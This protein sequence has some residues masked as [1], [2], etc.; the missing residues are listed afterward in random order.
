MNQESRSHN[1]FFMSEKNAREY[2]EHSKTGARRRFMNLLERF[3]KLDIKGKYLEVGCGP[4]VLACMVANQHPDVK[5]TATD[6]SPQMLSIAKENLEADKKDRIQFGIAD[7]CDHNS[8]NE[9]GNFN[10]IY[11]TFTLHHWKN[12]EHAIR[13]LYNKLETNGLL[14]I[15]DLKPVWWL[16]II[17]SKSGFIKSVRTSLPTKEIRKKITKL[18]IENYRIKTVAPWFLQVVEIQ[19]MNELDR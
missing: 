19:K 10:L 2:Y 17:P 7:A 15:L 5:I 1:D 8:L 6:I 14:Y 16:R 13:N 12:P 18:G 3:R 4:G 11:T 9:Y